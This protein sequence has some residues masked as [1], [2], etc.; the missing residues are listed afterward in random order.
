MLLNARSLKL[1]H[2]HF[3]YF[4]HAFSISGICKV[5][6]HNIQYFKENFGHVTPAAKG[7]LQAVHV[8]VSQD[9]L[10]TRYKAK[11]NQA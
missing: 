6:A 10:A 11:T 9:C 5:I 3:W 1:G 7:P 4:Q 2:F 8:G